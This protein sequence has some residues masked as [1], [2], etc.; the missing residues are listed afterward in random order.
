MDP[1]LFN[2]IVNGNENIIIAIS[3]ADLKAIVNTMVRGERERIDKELKEQKERPTMTRQQAA[4]ALNVS[5]ST[6]YNWAE[7]GYL[8]PC[9]IGT[10]V[11]Y[12]ASDI[13]KLLR[14][15]KYNL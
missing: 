15:K 13:E 6:L 3:A 2:Q 11:L 1:Q 9:K 10:K 5:I 14:T 4:E 7:C 12:I 8:V